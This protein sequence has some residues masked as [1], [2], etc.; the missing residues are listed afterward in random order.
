M[1]IAYYIVPGIRVS[2]F[3][4][5]LIAALVLALVNLLIRPLILL[6][7]LPFNVLTLGLFT[8]VINA[9]LFWFTSTMVKGFV[10]DGFWPAFW[11]AFA[12]WIVNWILGSLFRTNSERR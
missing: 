12:M 2:N 6:L 5:A 4:A 3:Y 8:L 1:A 10:V 9:L 11:G 7:T